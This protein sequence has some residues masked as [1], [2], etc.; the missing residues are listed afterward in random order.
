V[1]GALSRL[2]PRIVAG[3]NY[4]CAQ[5]F[6]NRRGRTNVVETIAHANVAFRLVGVVRMGQR[7]D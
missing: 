7:R 4:R 3:R 1:T 2:R 5:P 6:D